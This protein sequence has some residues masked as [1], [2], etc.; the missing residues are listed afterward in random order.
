MCHDLHQATHVESAVGVYHDYG[1]ILA[2]DEVVY[3]W[4]Y[5]YSCEK[6][7][8]TGPAVP[9]SGGGDLDDRRLVGAGDIA[10]IIIM[11]SWW[12]RKIR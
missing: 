9:W 7:E 11:S 4:Q 2:E 8:Q 1:R 6:V 12:P 3:A 10:C 5:G